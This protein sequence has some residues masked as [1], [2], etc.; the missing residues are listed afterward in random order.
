MAIRKSTLDRPLSRGERRRL[1]KEQRGQEIT[2]KGPSPEIQKQMRDERLAL[3]NK[4]LLECG[5]E[6]GFDNKYIDAIFNPSAPYGENRKKLFGIIPRAPYGCMTKECQ[7]QNIASRRSEIDFQNSEL[8]KKMDCLQ[9]CAE[10]KFFAM[11]SEAEIAAL[12]RQGKDTTASTKMIEEV[13][14]RYNSQCGSFKKANKSEAENKTKNLYLILG[15]I[16][17]LLILKK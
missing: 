14:Y 6:L 10:G 2:R 9:E 5:K 15:A 8:G 11:Q 16:V 17:V 7:D 12:K 4:Y 13:N 3:R 1:L